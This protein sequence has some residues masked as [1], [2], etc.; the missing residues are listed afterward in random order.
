MAVHLRNRKADR[1]QISRDL[2]RR[3]SLF[4]RQIPPP[5]TNH[6]DEGVEPEWPTGV[7]IRTKQCGIHECR[8]HQSAI[9]GATGPFLGSHPLGLD[10]T[11]GVASLPGFDP[12]PVDHRIAFQRVGVAPEWGELRI[13]AIAE[14]SPGEVRGKASLYRKFLC[15][16]L[17]PNG[18]ESP[19]E[20]GNCQGST[21]R[22][23]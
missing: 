3:R 6:V 17:T 12:Q 5:V 4:E 15:V 8:C 13:R 1:V 14:V 10:P 22:S 16:D 20:L 18:F 2:V 23:S 7:R 11:V 21:G 9:K 19:A